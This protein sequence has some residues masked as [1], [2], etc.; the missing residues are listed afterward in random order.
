MMARNEGNARLAVIPPATPA[1]L[2]AEPKTS[3]AFN[4]G[5]H[6]TIGDGEPLSLRVFVATD[7]GGETFWRVEWRWV[8]SVESLGGP[9]P[10]FTSLAP[11]V[12]ADPPQMPI[13]HPGM[14]G[15]E[16]QL[17]ASDFFKLSPDGENPVGEYLVVNITLDET[18]VNADRIGLLLVELV[19]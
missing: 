2:L 1:W 5:R 7:G 19:W 4:W 6:Q 12:P 14:A 15:G 13:N 18:N 8:T 3:L 9:N 10:P 16:L 11:L 17:N